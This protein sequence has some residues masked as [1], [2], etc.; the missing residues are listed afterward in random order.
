[1]V[2]QLITTLVPLHSL[3]LLMPPMPTLVERSLQEMVLV[4]LVLVLLL[5]TFLA[6]PLL[7]LILQM[8]PTLQQELSVTIDFQI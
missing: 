5:P 4:I 3:L 8:V 2:R 7:L 6:L 1:V